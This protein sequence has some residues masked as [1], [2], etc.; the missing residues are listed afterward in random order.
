M[1]RL[2]FRTV[3]DW[4]EFSKREGPTRTVWQELVWR[5]HGAAGQAI[6]NLSHRK[7]PATLENILADCEQYDKQEHA[8]Q[9]FWFVYGEYARDRVI[10]GLGRLIECG[11][12]WSV[13]VEVE[14]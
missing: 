5:E 9:P 4:E 8:D 2:E 3:K 7:I 10:L 11:V 6:Q 1:K 14:K 13:E 12:V